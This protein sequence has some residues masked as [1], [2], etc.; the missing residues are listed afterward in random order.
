MHSRGYPEPSTANA[1]A[2]AART[3]A[4]SA[5]RQPGPGQIRVAVNVG[6]DL[7]GQPAEVRF[8]V[9]ICDPLDR[10]AQSEVA[11][12]TGPFRDVDECPGEPTSLQFVHAGS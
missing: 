5:F 4:K 3:L 1:D 9:L 6:A 8:G 7:G 2:L 11:G 10:Q 12:D